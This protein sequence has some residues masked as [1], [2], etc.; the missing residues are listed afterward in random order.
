M[1]TD[2][3]FRGVLFGL[4]G[5]IIIFPI[6]QNCLH[7]GPQQ[8]NHIALGAATPPNLPNP[9]PMGTIF[10]E[11]AAKTVPTVVSV[12]P[13]KIDTVLIYNNPFYNFFGDTS[14][15]NPFN[16]FFGFPRGGGG[17]PPVRKEQHREEALGAGASSHRTA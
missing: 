4:L 9:G 7:A 17:G 3:W 13:S 1:R 16:F 10:A 12:I 8:K 5:L 2:L 6:G 11:L 14:E 15:G